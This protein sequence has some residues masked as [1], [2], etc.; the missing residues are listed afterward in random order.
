MV[1]VARQVRVMAAHLDCE[2]CGACCVN[3][4][5]NRREGA[6]LWVEIEA[7]DELL[8]RKD[9]KKHVTYDEAGVP[10]L[11]MAPDDGRC[12]AL[13]GGIGRRVTCRIYQARPSPCRRVQAGD[14]LCLRYRAEHGLGRAGR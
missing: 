1:A 2:T 9:L 7:G 8:G 11:R 12:M 10:H 3:L 14:E 13:S 4:P 6:H 5:S